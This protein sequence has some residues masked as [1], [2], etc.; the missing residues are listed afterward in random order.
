VCGTDKAT[1]RNVFAHLMK[2][3]PE[4]QRFKRSGSLW[5]TNYYHHLINAIA[6]GFAFI[7]SDL[8]EDA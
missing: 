6:G 8:R 4:L 3:Y 5:E 7:T 1:N 2:I